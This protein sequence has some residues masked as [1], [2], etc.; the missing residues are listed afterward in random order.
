MTE[1]LA[2]AF[3]NTR[4]SRERDRIATLERFRAWARP[5]PALAGCAAEL[6]SDHLPDV[7]AHRD[8]TQLVLHRIAA[9]ERPPAEELD[10]ATGPG[11]SPAGFRIRPVP[12]G[13]ALDGT[14]PEAV[15]HLL[16]RALVDFLL[17]Q[18]AEQLRRCQGEGCHK[19]FVSTRAHRRWCDSRI[20][21][22]R[23]RVAAHARRHG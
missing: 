2:L 11:L 5:W 15:Q 6:R 21:G 18:Q 9:G 10:F 20:C 16:G 14:G 12:G 22:N 7:L 19:V 23:A 1:P 4:S 17:G 13:V 8:A 3:A